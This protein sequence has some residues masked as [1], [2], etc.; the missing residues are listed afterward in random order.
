MC[1]LED[2]KV[3]WPEVTP[4][5]VAKIEKLVAPEFEGKQWETVE[6]EDRPRER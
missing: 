3:D 2:Y 4:E 5:Q 1:H 6:S